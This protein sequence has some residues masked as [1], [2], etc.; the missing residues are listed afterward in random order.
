MKVPSATHVDLK[1]IT[2]VVEK[3]GEDGV[4]RDANAAIRLTTLPMILPQ[5]AVLMSHT[6]T[7]QGMIVCQNNLEQTSFAPLGAGDIDAATASECKESIP[8]D[9]GGELSA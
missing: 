1:I 5:P 9:T 4:L 3:Y 2:Y 7:A 8:Q 6:T